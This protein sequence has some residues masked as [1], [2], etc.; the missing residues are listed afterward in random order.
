MPVFPCESL[1]IGLPTM[2][3]ASGNIPLP[4]GNQDGFNSVKLASSR[5]LKRWN[6]VG[7]RESFIPVS[8]SSFPLCVCLLHGGCFGIRFRTPMSVHRCGTTKR[9]NIAAVISTSFQVHFRGFLF[10]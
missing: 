8:L 2:F 10:L 7:R 6:K 4:R 3:E 1:Y 5:D 9:L